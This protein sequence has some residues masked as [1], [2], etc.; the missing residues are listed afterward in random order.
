MRSLIRRNRVWRSEPG[1]MTFPSHAIVLREQLPAPGDHLGG[2]LEASVGHFC[3][4]QH[5]GDFVGA[6][7]VVEDADAGLRAA[8]LLAFFDGEMLVGEGGD[9]REVGN[10]EDLLGAGESFELLADG[11]SGAASDADVYL[12]EDQGA[13]GGLLLLGFGCA[14]FDADFEGQHDARHFSA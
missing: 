7:T 11:F 14:L 13:R 12:V 9:L 2:V 3:A 5:A 1:R 10:A 6:G 8:V 4:G